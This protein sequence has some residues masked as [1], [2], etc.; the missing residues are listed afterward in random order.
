MMTCDTCRDRLLDHAYGLLDDAEVWPVEAHLRDCVG[1]H[2]EAERA[3]TL[4]ARAAKSPFPAVTFTPPAPKPAEPARPGVRTVREACLRWAVAAGLLL[5]AAGLAGPAATDLLV[6]ASHRPDAVA[7]AARYEVALADTNRTARAFEGEQEK[8]DAAVDAARRAHD[9]AAQTWLVAEADAAKAAAARPFN[10]E[11]DGPAS[12]LPGAP[13]EYRLKVTGGTPVKFAATATGPDGTVLFRHAAEGA[14][15]T[16]TLPAAVWAKLPPGTAPTLT[17]TATDPAGGSAATVTESLKQVEPRGATMLATDRPLYQPGERVYYRSLTLD[18][19]TLRPLDRPLTLRFAVRSPDGKPVP[20][21]EVVGLATPV[22]DGEPVAGPDGKPL[23]G[24]AAG[25]FDLPPMLAGGEYTLTVHEVEPGKPVPAPDAKPLA[26]RKFLVHRTTPDRF[27]KT[28]ELD[29]RSYGPGDPVRAKLTVRDQSRPVSATLRVTAHAT[30]AGQPVDV[31]V[32][33][34]PTTTDAAGNAAILVQLPAGD[35]ADASLSVA[36]TANGVTE[37]I[38]KPIPLATRKLTVEFFPEGGDLV[39]GVSNRVYFRATTTAGKPADV[40]GTLS[41]GTP[42][43]TLTD[44]DHPGVNQGLGV[45]SFTPKAGETYHA[46]LTTPTHLDPPTPAGYPLPAVKPAGVVLSVPE[47][48]TAANKPLTVT[49]TAVGPKRRVLVGAYARGQ[50]LGQARGELTPGTPTPVALDLAGSP[51]GGVTRV[52]VFDDPEG[53]EEGRAELKPLAERLVFRHPGNVLKVTASA[54]PD[55]GASFLPGD[56]VTLTVTTTDEAGAPKPAVLWAAVVNQSTLT[57]A[58]DRSAR[59]LPTHFLLSGEVRDPDGLEKSDFLLTDHPKA[60]AALDLVLGTQGWRRFA[61][62]APGAFKT[63]T[64]AEA[65][66]LLTAMGGNS[67]SLVG[68]TATTAR[69]AAVHLPRFEAATAA[70]ADAERARHDES[71]LEPLRAE[72]TSS[73]G[74]AQTLYSALDRDVRVIGHFAGRAESRVGWL[75]LTALFTLGLATLLGFLSWHRATGWPAAERK[76]LRRGAVGLV[77]VALFG[78][79]ATLLASLASRGLQVT[80]IPNA[81]PKPRPVLP[82]EMVEE[83]PLPAPSNAR[84]RPGK[85]VAVKMLPNAAGTHRGGPR[86]PAIVTLRDEFLGRPTPLA[87]A[88]GEVPQ[89]HVTAADLARAALLTGLRAS[90]DAVRVPAGATVDPDSK[91]RVLLAIPPEPTLVVR[92]YAHARPTPDPETGT[93]PAGPPPET[94]LWQP[95]LITPADGTATLTFDLPDG[96]AGYQVLVA[97]NTLDGR[98]G[99]TVSTI[100]VRK[101]FA[102]AAKLPPEVGSGDNLLIPVTLTNATAGSVTADVAAF[103]KN[104][105]VTAVETVELPAHS[106]G[107]ALLPLSFPPAGGL[108]TLTVTATPRGD[109]AD[110]LR[111]TLTVVPDGYPVEGAASARLGGVTTLSLNLPRDFDAGTLTAT[112]TAYP[113][114]V[115]EAQAGLAGLLREPTGCFEQA[116]SANYPNVLVLDLLRDSKPAAP[117]ASRQARDLLD[118]GYARLTGYECPS[119]KGGRVGFEWFGAADR[120]HGALTAYALTQFADMSRVFPVDPALLQRTRQFLL[121]AR[122]GV[123]GYRFPADAVHTF[124]KAPAATVAAYTTWAITQAE[125]VA[126]FP[127]PPTDLTKELDAQLELAAGPQAKD[128]Y[129]LALTA[130]AL[131][132]RDRADDAAKLLR[133][134]VKLQDAAGRVGGEPVSV[135]PSPG[136]S[137]AVEATAAAALAWAQSA[138][139]EFDAPLHTALGWLTNQ[140]DAGGSFGTTQATVMALKALAEQSRRKPRPS[141]PGLV[142]VRANGKELGRAR[143]LPDA[144][145]PVAVPLSATALAGVTAVAVESTGLDGVPV[146]LAWHARAATPPSARDGPLRLTVA[147]DKPTYAEGDTARLRV[148]LANDAFK[149]VDMAT[150]VVGLPAGLTLPPDLK[151]LKALTGAA[152]GPPKVDYF[153]VRGRELVL[154]RRGLAASETVT[155]SLDTLAET[156]GTSRGPASR[157][158]PY[159]SPELTRWAAPL[160]VTITPTK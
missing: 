121:D 42:I 34:N 72:L 156:P 71:G 65:E 152:D 6:V 16:V 110:V 41:D 33:V 101:P 120:P 4:F 53:A 131:L 3:T 128:P 88:V 106:G 147:L 87:E 25:A 95:V 67:R 78:I 136:K 18:R 154:Y 77:A 52:T 123:G 30:V 97:G 111:R 113:S 143:N 55:S 49:L 148:T 114:A 8:L 100:E 159:Y 46:K 79:T 60:A 135:T 81:H 90:L 126:K 144:T 158:Y 118:R 21:S 20:G 9:V 138:R 153:E 104:A 134:I 130:G 149:A 146:T 108:A 12:A 15:A 59:L 1:C 48:V 57:M 22:R 117:E 74:Q 86:A 47:G 107:R 160:A 17:V 119:A 122:D 85:G 58:D 102:A 105:T 63:R 36:V 142:I 2:T 151:Q 31:K 62:Q 24:V 7:T 27:L 91:Q 28:L 93:L 44:P 69:L 32:T 54:K 61:E 145:G 29:G 5:A 45:F 80:A 115:A 66:R 10:L 14:T 109:P 40:A 43:R 133:A 137:L 103:G 157:A 19:A 82:D 23:R 75:P 83:P 50:A 155:F 13:N 129:F 68:Y 132:A 38:T 125:A 56:P 37:T 99:A 140:R 11:I 51:L 127:G 96:V 73:Q 39:A 35:V 139:P 94:L 112:V 92:E 98:L 124:G 141:E 70:L 64:P 150:F 116:S 76:W 26:E 89:R 84:V